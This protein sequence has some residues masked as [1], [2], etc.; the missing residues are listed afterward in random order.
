MRVLRLLPGLMAEY[1]RTG[2]ADAL[3]Y[4]AGKET[5][6]PLILYTQQTG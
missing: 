6:Y 2:K 5:Q 3:R 1:I 4:Q